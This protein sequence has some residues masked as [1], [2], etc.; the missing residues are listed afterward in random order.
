MITKWKRENSRRLLEMVDIDRLV[1][2]KSPLRRIDAA[3]RLLI[4][5]DGTRIPLEDVAELEIV[6]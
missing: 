5:A 4:L 3:A 1:P 2:K 6:E